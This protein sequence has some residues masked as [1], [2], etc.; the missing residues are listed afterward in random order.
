[1]T[2]YKSK[3][4]KEL[5]SLEAQYGFTRP[6]R[7]S[8]DDPNIQWREGKPDYRSLDLLYYK[9]KNKNHAVGSLEMIV[10]N[11]VKKWEMQMTYMTSPKDWSTVKLDEFRVMVNH[12]QE[13]TGQDAVK[14]GTYNWVMKEISKDLYDA[15]NETFESSHKLF[16]GAFSGGFPW[17]VLEVYSGPPKVA[18]SWHH[19]GAF[20]GEYK[21]VKGDGQKIELYGFTI[22]TVNSDL[23]ILKLEVY[24]KFEGFLRALQGKATPEDLVRGQ[25]LVG[26]E[27]P[28][29]KQVKTK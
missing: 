25:E 4:D 9:G 15:E 22:A 8:F 17:E 18:F 7:G 24:L 5:E 13:M 26:T 14:V 1:M 21:G 27:C 6:D 16:R 12:G 2:A 28:I 10:E 23:K 20:S 19:W 11:L 29:H 3:L